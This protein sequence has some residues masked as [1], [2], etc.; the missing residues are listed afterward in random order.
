M[1]FLNKIS[2]NILDIFNKRIFQGEIYFENG[3]IN[4]IIEKK[5]KSDVFISPGLIDAHIHIESSM[6]TPQHFAEVAVRH[7]TTGLLA[8]PHEISNVLGMEGVRY[9][10]ENAKYAPVKFFFGAPSCVPATCFDD[11]GSIISEE[12]INN[13]FFEEKVGF[14]S[15]MMNY[16]GVI[17]NDPEVCNKI[18]IAKRFGKKIDGHAP[19]LRGKKLQKYINSGIDTDHECISMAE[20]V[21]KIKRGMKIII[22]EGSA[23]KN[24]DSLFPLIHNFPEKIMFCTD[25]LHPDDL[26]KGHINLLLKK[27][28][29]RNADIFNVFRACTLNPVE[30]YKINA[31]LL[32]LNDPADITVFDNKTNLQVI[33]TIC[34]GRLVFNG[35]V[36]I[37][38]PGKQK[39]INNFNSTEISP[40]ML[41]ICSV[42]KKI[43]II[44]AIDKQLIT[45]SIFAKT[46]SQG[47][48]LCPDIKNDFLKI[49]VLNRYKKEKPSIGFINGFGLQRGAIAGSIAH[50]SHNIIAIGTCDED[51][52]ELI[53]WIVRNKGGI[54]IYD[55]KKIN[56]ITLPV[57]GIISDKNA[58][59]V[60][61]K[62]SNLNCIAY[63]LG[64]K[65]S[66]PFMTISFMSL[67]V[68]PEL[69][70]SNRGLFD[71]KSFTFTDL[72]VS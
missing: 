45:K 35:E 19:G 23:A 46:I 50:D 5:I 69:K 26:L 3:F 9:M 6:L 4:R 29:S 41:R 24:F 36:P 47:G 49:V 31:G 38:T 7:G 22:R 56:G 15:E 1:N 2:G 68:I 21:E 62:Y 66:S 32:R 27:A 70:I 14:L 61:E 8:D 25:D 71:V 18:K 40:D 48:F 39:H 16:P 59:S 43:R 10:T 58:E 64:C 30:H 13:L 12:D 11:T 55:G 42:N 63:S 65:L 51:I 57:A 67:L 53:N 20:A 34:D 52:T 37:Y 54:G 33:S 72:F 17:N 28:I 44:K 60:A